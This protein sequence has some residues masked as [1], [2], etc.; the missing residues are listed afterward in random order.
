MRS[1]RLY[2]LDFIRVIATFM[3]ILFHYN[4]WT[5]RIVSPAVLLVHNYSFLGA[6]GVSLF[7]ILSGAALFHSTR[8]SFDVR[9]FYKGRFLA[10]FPMFYLVYS[11]FMILAL[12]FQ[13]Y[14]LTVPRS[15]FAFLLTVAGLDGLL[16]TV[17]PTY[18]LTGEWFLGCIVILYLIFPGVRF[19]FHLNQS[20]AL[21]LAVLL[22][23]L[24]EI[25]YAFP[26]P[27][28]RLPL[29]RLA[30]FVFGMYI[31]SHLPNKGILFDCMIVG[32]L[33][34]SLL[35]LNVAAKPVAHSIGMNVCG[36]LAFIVISHLSKLFAGEFIA[37]I[38]SFFRRYSY[39]AFLVHHIILKQLLIFTS[40]LIHSTLINLLFFFLLV[41]I[42]YLVAYIFD[43][44]LR[45]LFRFVQFLNIQRNRQV[46]S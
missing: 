12:V 23:L 1:D 36:M 35:A 46:A 15:P 8:K 27:L 38:V 43:A 29:F 32:V 10:L 39:P 37:P 19:L 22:F 3:I 26:F 14:D 40:P 30:E 21:L 28:Q 44:I 31:L 34:A 2:H 41:I 18:Y 20:A 9:T 33:L 11:C 42:V 17:I 6:V 24:L 16:S 45:Q 13:Q 5:E 4:V 25:F 7:I